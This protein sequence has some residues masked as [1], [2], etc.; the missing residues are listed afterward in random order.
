MTWAAA[1][2]I[3]GA[4]LA[5]RLTNEET[6][7]QG[8]VYDLSWWTVDGGSGILS[9]GSYALVGTIGQPDAGPTLG[10][11]RYTLVGGFWPGAQPASALPVPRLYLPLVL[12]DGL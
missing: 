2:L 12:Q 6:Q 1:L 4:L 8:T 10:G 9:G 5:L 7:A 3:V 11:G